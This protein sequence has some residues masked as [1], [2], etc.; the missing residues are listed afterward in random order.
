MNPF[1]FT[2]HWGG[3][4]TLLPTFHAVRDTKQTWF[5]FDV[6]VRSRPRGL[7]YRLDEAHGRKH[8][9]FPNIPKQPREV[10]NLTQFLK[11]HW[12]NPWVPWN[13]V[14]KSLAQ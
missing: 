10:T 13:T 14:S 3:H 11:T 8:R 9:P 2:I 6:L 4:Y 5:E 1:P 12:I 7:L